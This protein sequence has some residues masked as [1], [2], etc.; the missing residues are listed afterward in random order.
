MT[1]YRPRQDAVFQTNTFGSGVDF[2]AQFPANQPNPANNLLLRAPRLRAITISFTAS[3]TASTRQ[4]SF[5]LQVTSNPGAELGL[6]LASPTAVT[7]G[8]SAFFT[9]LPGCSAS[10]VTVGTSIFVL[11]PIPD[12]QGQ[13]IQLASTTS[14]IVAGDQWSV[15]SFAY[16]EGGG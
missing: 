16:T 8:E 10:A 14:G 4:T 15:C 2:I 13:Q 9:F 7:A 3:G 11:L 1:F 5:R 12:L 6:Q